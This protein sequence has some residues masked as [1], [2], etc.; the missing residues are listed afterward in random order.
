MPSQYYEPPAYEPGWSPMAPRLRPPMEYEAPLTWV[1]PAPEVPAV[2]PPAAPAAPAT[3]AEKPKGLSTAAK[4]GIGFV[5]VG[6]IV[7]GVVLVV[8]ARKKKRRR[9]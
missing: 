7:T 1:P 6:G 8:R 3:E 9:R 5:V 2:A 4:V